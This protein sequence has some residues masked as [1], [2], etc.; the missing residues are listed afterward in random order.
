[1]ANSQSDFVMEFSIWAHLKT[2]LQA[3]L[4]VFLWAFLQAF[5]WAHLWAFLQAHLRAHEISLIDA[6]IIDK[7]LV[8]DDILFTNEPACV[9][10]TLLNILKF[11]R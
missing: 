9:I 2:H 10:P 11:H 5:L 7:H 3:H 8:E 1:M 6:F 4:W